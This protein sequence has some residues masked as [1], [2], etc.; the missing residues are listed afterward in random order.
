MKASRPPTARRRG[1][2]IAYASK[3]RTVVPRE[4]FE[5]W[6]CVAIW[7]HLLQG[8]P[9]RSGE[10]QD[11][12]AAAGKRKRIAPAVDRV[13]QQ[14]KVLARL[15]DSPS[16]TPAGVRRIWHESRLLYPNA[17]A[18]AHLVLAG[19]GVKPKASRP[20]SAEIKRFTAWARMNMDADELLA[21]TRKA[22]F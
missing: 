16:L 7:T 17:L 2:R 14:T 9:L 19:Q 20:V 1:R 10:A 3:S 22:N 13:A 4:A 12:R 6:V 15:M 18:Q 8:V 11:A 5:W 21:W